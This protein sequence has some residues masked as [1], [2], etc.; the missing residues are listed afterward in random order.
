MQGHNVGQNA[1]Q[2]E[3]QVAEQHMQE[4][5]AETLLSQINSSCSCGIAQI[6]SAMLGTAVYL[7]FVR[8]PRVAA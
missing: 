3:G 8:T 1:E 4:A 5:A 7:Q 2:N 6:Q